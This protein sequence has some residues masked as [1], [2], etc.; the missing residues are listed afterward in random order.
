MAQ[1]RNADNA[2][3]VALPN[4]TVRS[5]TFAEGTNRT[6]ESAVTIKLYN[7]ASRAPSGFGSAT[8]RL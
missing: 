2:N 3:G 1:Q 8:I 5:V 4:H 7:G 6:M